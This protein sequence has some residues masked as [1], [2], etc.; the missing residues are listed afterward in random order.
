MDLSSQ[1]TYPWD[2]TNTWVTIDGSTRPILQMEL[3]AN[4]ASPDQL[5]LMNLAL[6]N[7]YTLWNNIDLSN[8]ADVW[9]PS[10]GAGFVI[11]SLKDHPLMGR[12][13]DKIIRF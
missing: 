10:S 8:N 3:S 11:L 4:I 7:N 9:G 2:F 5:E 6:N 12:L 1:S 13:T